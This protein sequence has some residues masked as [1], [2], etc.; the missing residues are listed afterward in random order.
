MAVTRVK[1][2]S[3]LQG[4]PKDR[5]FLAG[6]DAYDP[7]DFE[8]I[9]TVTVGSGGSGSISFTSIP[10][11]YAHLQIRYIADDN[12]SGVTVNSVGGYFNADN[13]ASNYY[14]HHLD[15]DGSSASAGANTGISG[16]AL[17]F[18]FSTGANASANI[19]GVSVVDILDYAN[20][21]KY[22]TMRLLTGADLNGS[23]TVRFG[24]GLWKNTAAVTDITILPV[25]STFQQ[26]SHFALYGI[27]G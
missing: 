23:G 4:M 25:S 10:G 14:W 7:P 9:A 13:T 3:L 20:T 5:S 18:G 11:T 6:N 8:S 24:S 27:K 12:R 16:L 21:N 22:T 26:Y 2:S 15:G 19:F 17:N 1:T